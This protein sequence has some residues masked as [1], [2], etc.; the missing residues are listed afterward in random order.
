[1]PRSKGKFLGISISNLTCSSK[2]IPIYYFN[3]FPFLFEQLQPLDISELIFY[4]LTARSKDT[5]IL[6]CLLQIVLPG[7][8]FQT[9]FF[10]FKMFFKR[11]LSFIYQ[12]PPLQPLIALK[13]DKCNK[14]AFIVRKVFN[15]ISLLRLL[16]VLDMPSAVAS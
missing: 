16:Q 13:Y 12:R 15:F 8:L 1:M 3:C 10:F 9:K 7:N 14:L 5:I 4:L 2:L 6:K 11:E